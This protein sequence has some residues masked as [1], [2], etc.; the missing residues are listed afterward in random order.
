MTTPVYQNFIHGQFVPNQSKETFAVKNPATDEVIY[1]VE[2]AD[3]SIQEKA[4]A[5]AREGFAAWSAMAPIERS[6]I[7]NKAVYLLRERN[8]ELAKIEVLDTGKPIQEADCVDIQTG[9]DVI[10]Y[11]AGLAPTQVGTQQPVG[12]DFFYTRKEP[13]G[14]CAGIG[15]WNYPLQI[16]CWKSGPAL[17][18]GN[19]LIFKP[20]EET[21]LGAIKLAEVFIEA[22]MP[23]GVFNVVQGAA[24]VGQWLT[25]HPEIEKVSFTGEVGTGKKVMQSAASNL[26]DVTME[27]G[28][29][30][31]LIVFDDADIAEAVSAAMLGNFYTQGEICTNCTRVYVHKSVYTQF[32]KELKARTEANIIAGDPL[33]PN[34]NLGALISKKH[35]ELVL[36]YIEKGK[37]EGA[38]LLTGG[39]ALSPESAPNG[40]FVAP[41]IFTDCTDDM[42]IVREEIFGPVMSVL[43]FEDEA[44]VITRANNTELGLGAGVFSQNIQ[45]AHR[46]IHQLKAGICWINSY[47]NSPAEMPVGGYKQSGIGR[48]NGIET[49]NSYT[50]TKSVYVGMSQIE[51]PF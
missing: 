7:L 14:I 36:D 49:L 33:N 34:V 35:Q 29:K 23:A 21:P 27:L 15:A 28:G 37:A 6:R 50:Q 42:T 20:S 38:T 22:G 13:L 41:T 11:F 51:S 10:E 18:A 47:G 25:T 2:V 24:E 39:H 26:K 32:I 46:V 9:A 8:D 44:D 12:N 17:A 40:Y 30:S 5:S 31:P 43:V 16:A 1:H 19:V 48:E 45:R 4:I 3:E